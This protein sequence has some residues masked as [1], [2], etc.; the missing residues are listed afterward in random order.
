MRKVI[1]SYSQP[2]RFVGVGPSQ[3]SR[4][5]VLTKRSAASGE[6]NNIVDD[7]VLTSVQ[8]PD[9]ASQMDAIDVSCIRFNHQTSTLLF[10]AHATLV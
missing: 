10:D 5:L 1:V 6:E 8:F 4:F 3:R 7:K 9:G 2:I